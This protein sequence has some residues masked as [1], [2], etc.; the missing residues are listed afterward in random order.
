MGRHPKAS[1][2]NRLGPVPAL[3]S[4]F[5]THVLLPS[6]ESVLVL[7][8]VGL[9]QDD[10]GQPG[11]AESCAC[12]SSD[13][14]PLFDEIENSTDSASRGG[15]TQLRE[16]EGSSLACTSGDPNGLVLRRDGKHKLFPGGV[17]LDSCSRDTSTQRHEVQQGHGVGP[18]EIA[19]CA[20]TLDLLEN[21]A[22]GVDVLLLDT[23]S[24]GLIRS[25]SCI[26]E[27]VEHRGVYRWFGH[28]SDYK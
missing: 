2:H 7:N 1:P 8:N 9:R 5:Q 25:N 4:L 6:S 14:S 15:F 12:K 13:G 16:G 18:V 21:R 3:E 28:D 23:L 24:D 17:G 11:L 10:T 19:V 26:D 20:P 27:T 22:S